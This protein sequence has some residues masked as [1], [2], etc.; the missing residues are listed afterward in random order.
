MQSLIYAT[1]ILLKLFLRKF[2]LHSFTFFNIFIVRSLRTLNPNVSLLP[3]QPAT[4]LIV[5]MY[6]L[7]TKPN[8]RNPTALQ[9]TVYQ[10]R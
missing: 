2:Y 5:Q 10:S 1:E 9:Q 7:T 3:I 4:F 6:V 8:R